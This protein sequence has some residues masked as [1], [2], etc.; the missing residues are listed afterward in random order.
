MVD[1]YCGSEVASCNN[2]ENQNFLDK[3]FSR[4]TNEHQSRNDCHHVPVNEEE[5]NIKTLVMHGHVL[6]K[7]IFNLERYKKISCEYLMQQ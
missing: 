5:L 3:M 1:A 4:Q 2:V 7:K 6:D